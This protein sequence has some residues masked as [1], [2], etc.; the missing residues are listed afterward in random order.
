MDETIAALEDQGAIIIDNTRI[1]IEPAYD[2]EFTALLCEF[3][4]DIAGY[5]DTYTR[6]RY[7][8]TLQ[9]L[10]DFNNAHPE[11]EGPVELADLR[12]RPGDGRP[13]RSGL[14]SRRAT[15]RRRPPRQR[16]T[17]RWPRTT[18]TRSFPRRTDRLG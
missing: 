5:L 7:P 14:H 6:H 15:L 4:D 13:G 17:T 11:L 12:S 16:S 9:D 10:I 8:K 1:P 2:P 3:K 18:S